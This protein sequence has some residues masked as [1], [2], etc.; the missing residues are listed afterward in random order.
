MKLK[1]ILKTT[2]LC[3]FYLNSQSQ[4][5]INYQ[6]WNGGSA[7]NA[8]VSGVDVPSTLDGTNSTSR[9]ITNIGQPR[10]S[11][12]D[13]AITLDCE[14]SSGN[15]GTQFQINNNFKANYTYKIVINASRIQSSGGSN[16]NLVADL[17]NGGNG[18]NT[19]CNGVGFVPVGGGSS[20]GKFITSNTFVDYTYNFNN[21]LPQMLGNLIIYAVPPASAIYQTIEIRKI[22]ITE[23]A[24]LG[25]TPN[26][27]LPNTTNIECGSTNPVSFFITNTNNTPNITSYTWDLGTDN[28]G[29]TYSNS[30]APRYITTT[31]NPLILNPQNNCS[32]S[33][34]ISAVVKVNNQNYPTNTTTLV[35][36]LNSQTAV[37]GP[38]TINNTSLFTISNISCNTTFNWTASP[39]NLVSFDNP[40]SGNVNIT[41]LADGNC[42]LSSEVTSCG[43]TQTVTKVISLVAPPP[44]SLL[45][46][47]NSFSAY[48]TH[49]GN[50]Y[51]DGYETVIFD[52][53]PN[54]VSYEI[55]S[56]AFNISTGQT[57]YLIHTTTTTSPTVVYT[58]SSLPN[59]QWS[60]HFRVR[61]KCQ[62]GFYGDY[63]PWSNNYLL[64]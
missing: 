17:N 2:I 5:I 27:T 56:Q 44:C 19:G 12:T 63:S 14:G 57:L 24:P 29:W 48:T 40:T 23:I 7:C 4:R 47:S 18:V 45:V 59:N 64:N 42:T 6:T 22:T 9:H 8:F 1:L 58:S 61:A 52:L 41:R 28:N 49:S 3:L 33:N 20:V 60:F 46:N 62:N 37:V 26:F 38:S 53:V 43:I 54:A 15:K 21:P 32:P 50:S 10:Y 51:H 36:V 39:A 25:P 13:G 55:E 11:S 30:P 35:S 31:N 34:T 16:P